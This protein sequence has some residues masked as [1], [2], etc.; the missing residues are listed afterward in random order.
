MEEINSYNAHAD[1]FQQSKLLSS[2]MRLA[3]PSTKVGY[4]HCYLTN[5]RFCFGEARDLRDF[6]DNLSTYQQSLLRYF[7]FDM[8]RETKEH[9]VEDWM[10]YC[11]RLPPNLMSIRLSLSGEPWD[12]METGEGRFMCCVED[13]WPCPDDMVEVRNLVG[14][15]ARRFA[16]KAKIGLRE[17]FSDRIFIYDRERWVRV[18]HEVEPWSKNWLEWWEE[19]RKSDMFSGEEANDM[20]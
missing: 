13:A 19:D 4:E 5:T 6:L 14:N 9:G 17:G 18:L 1:I 15:C 10:A 2:G 3:S 7:V 8:S 11:A 12:V 20:A 16:P